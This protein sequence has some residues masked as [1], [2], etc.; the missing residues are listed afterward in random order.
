MQPHFIFFTVL[1]AFKT[2]CSSHPPSIHPGNPPL[3]S[4][5]P[6]TFNICMAEDEECVGGIHSG[7]KKE[8]EKKGGIKSYQASSWKFG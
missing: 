1:S 5:L 8:Q 4:L 3:L 7:L 6:S 2:E